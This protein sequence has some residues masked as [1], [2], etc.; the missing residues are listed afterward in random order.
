M[1]FTEN[2]Y[3]EVGEKS[4]GIHAFEILMERYS[5]AIYPEPHPNMMWNIKYG[6]MG[7]WGSTQTGSVFVTA[8]K[9][10]DVAQKWLD[11]YRPDILYPGQRRPMRSMVTTRFICKRS[12]Q[13]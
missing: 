6:H 10:L 3:A 12:R 2:I 8:E 1:E 5:G 9:A 4:T 11:Q 13:E 7:G